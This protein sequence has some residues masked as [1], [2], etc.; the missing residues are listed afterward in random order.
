MVS[1][2]DDGRATNLFSGGAPYS[3]QQ[4]HDSH[5]KIWDL[6]TGT[7]RQTQTTRY[8]VSSVAISADNRTVVGQGFSG[9]WDGYLLDGKTVAQ[10]QFWPLEADSSLATKTELSANQ[11][12]LSYFSREGR[13]VATSAPDAFKIWDLPTGNLLQTLPSSDANVQRLT[14]SAD[15]KTLAVWRSGYRPGTIELWHWPTGQLLHT[16]HIAENA[17]FRY[18]TALD[19][20]P[21]GQT[22]V[23]SLRQDSQRWEIQVWNA[24]AKSLRRTIQQASPVT[25]VTIS[26][27]G[28]TFASASAQAE[29][30]DGTLVRSKF[31]LWTLATGDLQRTLTDTELVKALPGFNFERELAIVYSP[32]GKTL[33]TGGFDG[34]IRLWSLDQLN[35]GH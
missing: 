20:S 21:D 32:D 27:D 35:S 15:G 4:N 31:S 2:G 23:C 18:L 17:T 16:L 9:T 29:S 5:V 28:K 6:S 19:I 30:E 1:G 14:F 8:P 10:V 7:V 12:Y 22:V 11:G 3:V 33:A 34:K 24:A 26:P 25:A 13:L